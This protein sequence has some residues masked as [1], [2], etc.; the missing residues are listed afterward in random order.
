MTT[1]LSP[2]TLA[3]LATGSATWAS[4]SA[5]KVEGIAGVALAFRF[6]RIAS[7]STPARSRPK[8]ADIKD[9]IR[10]EF[11]GADKKAARLPYE[12]CSLAFRIVEKLDAEGKEDLLA[13]GLQ[14]GPVKFADVLANLAG[15]KT[16]DALRHWCAKEGGADSKPKTAFQKVEAYLEKMVPDLS[17]DEVQSIVD[18]LL[19][20]LAQR[21]RIAGEI[22]DMNEALSRAS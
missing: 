18:G 4:G 17:A 21:T 6:E 3:F 14:D 13:K 15:A 9:A 5:A 8:V 1:K 22:A 7:L 12:A 11:G 20:N 10:A 2:E 19:A 16:E